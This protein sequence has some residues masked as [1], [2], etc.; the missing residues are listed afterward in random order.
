[1]TIEIFTQHKILISALF[2][3]FLLLLQW[4]VIRYLHKKPDDENNTRR[5]WIN[6]AKNLTTLLIFIG[7]LTLW[8][9]ELKYFALSVAA[10]A[11]A[12]VIAT[13]DILYCFVGSIYLA[14]T[15]SFD[16]GD[17]IKIGTNYGEVVS[18]DWLSTTVQEIDV[19]LQ[20]YAFTGRTIEIPNQLFI[21]TPVQN[22]NVMRRYVAHSFSITRDADKVNA[23][24][25][26]EQI[27][28]KAKQYCASF[29]EVA[30]RY[31][32]LLEIRLGIKISSEPDVRISTTNLGKNVFTITIFCPTQEA[33]TIEQKLTTDF[34][35]YWYQAVTAK[36]QEKEIAK[37]KAKEEE[38]IALEEG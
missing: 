29:Q 35:E 17:W 14:S 34:M 27:L 30:Q 26:K 13:R 10:F 24:E 12:T 7:L 37:A 38:I 9:S 8:L 32:N 28:A 2:I 20:S 6:R 5:I 31:S 36:N 3:V 25:L 16:V 1:M 33:V 23:V 4:I 22:M 11:V 15:R 21:T 19:D 18:S